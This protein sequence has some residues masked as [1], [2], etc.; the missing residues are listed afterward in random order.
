MTPA[1]QPALQLRDIHL[2]AE[3]GFWPPAPGW[4]IL[5]ALL[6]VLLARAAW[7]ATQRYRLRRQRQRILAMLDALEKDTGTTPEKIAQVSI[8]L[9]RLALMHYPRQRV[10]ALTGNDWLGFLDESG[11][12]G[13]F[14]HGPGRVLASAPYQPALPDDLDTR[15]L[16][17]LVRDWVKKNTER[18]HDN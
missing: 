7:V 14:S 1:A 13:R 18:R 5:A 10:A 16:G 8:L 9:R 4:W 3:P 17:E 15:A 11:G 12:G 6:F 2:P